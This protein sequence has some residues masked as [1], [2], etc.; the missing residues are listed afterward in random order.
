[1][2]GDTLVVFYNKLQNVKTSLLY[3]EH[4]SLYI[5]ADEAK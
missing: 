3:F 2:G 1:M 5:I 4:T